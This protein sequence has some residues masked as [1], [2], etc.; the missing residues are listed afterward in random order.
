M[1]V[2]QYDADAA[3]VLLTLA[4]GETVRA[5]RVIGAISP[6]LTAK[7]AFE[8]PCE[9]QHL[10][11]HGMFSGNSVKFHLQYA[12]PGWRAQGLSGEMVS[13]RVDVVV[14][15]TFD[16]SSASGEYAALL[17]VC[18]QAAV[19]MPLRSAQRMETRP[20]ATNATTSTAAIVAKHNG[21][22]TKHEHCFFESRRRQQERQRCRAHRG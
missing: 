10:G 17:F 15:C 18:A 8:P 11:A 13:N 7:I 22:T 1:R 19:R 5:R 4:S 2:A 6:Q 12:T 20:T 9:R 16:A 3:P 21:A 14:C